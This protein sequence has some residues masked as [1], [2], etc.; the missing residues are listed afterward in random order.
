MTI[1]DGFDRTA[2]GELL[3]G[4]LADRLQHA[5]AGMAGDPFDR[6][7]R[8]PNQ[9]VQDVQHVVVVE[10]V[11]QVCRRSDVE[12]VGEHRA[13]LQHEPFAGVEQVVGP[14]H[15]VAERLVAFEASPDTRQQPEPVIETVAHIL[16]RSSTPSAPRPARSPTRCRPAGGR[17]PCTAAT[18]FASSSVKPGLTARAR[19]TNNS[20]AADAA[21][22]H[23]QRRHGPQVLAVDP[24]TFAAGGEHLHRRRPGQDRLHQVGGRVEDVF[25]VVHDQQQPTARQRLRDRPGDRRSRPAA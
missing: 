18:S 22:V 5:V 19:S 2:G 14:A 3:L 13:M 6:Q 17:S 8:L 16:R 7:Q 20:T 23:V 25:A 4:V 11:V 24:Q 10:A 21:A 15:R 12:T 1:A 9:G